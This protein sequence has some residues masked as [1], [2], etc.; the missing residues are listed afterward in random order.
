[1]QSTRAAST[2][3]ITVRNLDESVKNCLRLR[4][5]RHG[6]SMEQEIRQ[7]L[8]ATVAPEQAEKI[9]F[10]ERVNRRFAGLSADLLLI[11]PRQIVRTLNV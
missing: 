4:A 1:L 6:G 11:L 8:Q 9:S 5:A 10:A 2:A 3:S 7:I